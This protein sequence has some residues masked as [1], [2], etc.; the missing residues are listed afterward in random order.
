MRLGKLI[1]ATIRN[2]NT[3]RAGPKRRSIF[4]RNATNGSRDI[5]DFLYAL[6]TMD[7]CK[8]TTVPF[9]LANA[10]ILKTLNE[11]CGDFIC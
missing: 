6:K 3:I 11:T 5:P 10:A 8:G 9:V 1:D 4:R 7:T 2:R